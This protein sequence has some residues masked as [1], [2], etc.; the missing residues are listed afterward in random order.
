[1]TNIISRVKRLSEMK[2]T[3]QLD[4]CMITSPS[5]VKYFS[6]Y[7]FYFEY[8]PSPFHLLPAICML[9]R[10][11][12]ISLIIADNETGRAAYLDP[13]VEISPYASYTFEQA[14]DPTGAC[15]RNILAYFQKKKL[16]ASRIGIEPDS[17]P[18]VI[19]QTL[20]ELFPSIEW[21]DV[22]S[23]INYLK[24][25]KDSDE[26]EMIRRSAGL[27]DIGQA[28]VLKYAKVGMSELELFSLAHRDIETFAGTRVP[29]MADL[30]TGINTRGGGGMPTNKIIQSGDLIISDFQP[31][32]HGYWGDSCNTMVVGAATPDQKKTWRLVREALEIGIGAIKPGMRANE[33]DKLLR[34]H[35]GN[36]PHHSGHSV[37]T[38][39]HEGPRITPYNETELVSGMVIALEPA[40]Y[41]ETYGIRLEHLMVVTDSGCDV[42]TKFKHRFEN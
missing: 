23:D 15:M 11:S 28:A 26:I 20:K 33:V 34:A 9:G 29:V 42:L 21:V 37:G 10:Q 8:G 19:T 14:A 27:A 25:I 2:E 3:K 16:G 38:S 24:S 4:A 32:L 40:I 12:D 18:F 22:S 35:I 39:S 5:S 13:I 36:Y 17:I 7:F 6:G 31:C 30:S 41:K 1:M